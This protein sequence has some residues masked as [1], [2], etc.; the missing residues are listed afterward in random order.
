[1]NRVDLARIA[2]QANQALRMGLGQAPGPDWDQAPTWVQ[3]STIQRVQQALD[4]PGEGER[5]QAPDENLEQR[6]LLAIVNVLRP[7][8]G[9]IPDPDEEG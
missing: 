2:H 7:V 3:E 1:M 4:S 5:H 6:L 9:V 8:L